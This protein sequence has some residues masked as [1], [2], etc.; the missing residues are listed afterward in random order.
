MSET[1]GDLQQLVMLGVAQLGED[2]SFGGGIQRLLE[3][4]AGR[5]VSVSTVYVTLVRLEERGLVCSSV[6]SG[7]GSVGRPRRTYRLTEEGWRA[8]REAK[9][10]LDRMWTRL[11]AGEARA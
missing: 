1:L 6:R 11:D 5:S 2:E 9:A 10:S 3:T 8:L 4:V 7:Q